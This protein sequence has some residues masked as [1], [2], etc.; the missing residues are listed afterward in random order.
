MET[1]L[2]WVETTGV[3]FWKD[4]SR[5]QEKTIL[6]NYIHGTDFTLSENMNE[7]KKKVSDNMSWWQMAIFI[8]L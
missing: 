5:N 2:P 1:L 7:F 3:L 4:S 6:N 8:R